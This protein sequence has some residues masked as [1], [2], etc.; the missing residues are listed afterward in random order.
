M[1]LH[2]NGE[3]RQKSNTA[4]MRITI[5]HLIAY[6]SP[7]GFSAGDLIST[8]TVAGVAGFSADPQ[9]WYLKPGDVVEATVSGVGTL[10]N[11]IVSWQEGRGEPV[12]TKVSL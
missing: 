8:G 4:N 12:P 7:Q 11:R 1:E 5:P 6:H 2:V 9:A 10:R 3:L